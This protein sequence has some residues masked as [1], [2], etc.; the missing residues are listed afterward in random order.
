M[1]LLLDKYE[2]LPRNIPDKQLSALQQGKEVTYFHD[3]LYANSFSRS[4]LCLQL[5]GY[6]LD[7]NA[8]LLPAY[9]AHDEVQN[10]YTL[11]KQ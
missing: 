5:L 6:M 10:T 8:A 4:S 9:F 3:F 2:R 1:R 7:R 11:C